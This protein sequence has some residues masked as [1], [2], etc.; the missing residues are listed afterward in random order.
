VR[1]HEINRRL[2]EN[3]DVTV[4]AA[5]W[6]GARDRVEDGVRYVHLGSGRT[7]ARALS[8]FARTP[9]RARRARADLI[10]EDFGAPISTVGI[11][12][13]TSTP[14]VAM[15]QW[16]FAAE[17]GAK[18]RLP[19][20]QVERWGIRQHRH[21]IAVSDDLAGDINRRN[22]YADVHVVPNGVDPAAFAT[23]SDPARFHDPSAP[24][25]FLGRLDTTQK[26]LDVLLQALALIPGRQLLVAGDGPDRDKLGRLASDL[27]VADRVRWLG[28][29]TGA[30]KYT[31]LASAAAVVI[32][33]RFETFGIVAIEAAAAGTPVLGSDIACLRSVVPDGVGVRVPADDARALAD[34]AVRLLAD[35][36]RMVRLS[37]SGRAFARGFDWPAIAARQEDIYRRIADRA[38]R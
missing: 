23:P 8:Y 10:I 11:P 3:H 7:R 9:H 32:P 25:V 19:F 12:R 2:A 38:L 24:L 21:F 17:L 26:G 29:V 1:T 33:S 34:A 37:I 5:G 16:M 20:R 27:G 4:L 35:P 28:R 14:V 30:A 18:Y 6:P 36:E 31:L 13:F 15:V 22:P